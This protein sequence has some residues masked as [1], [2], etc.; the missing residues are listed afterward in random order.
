MVLER[1]SIILREPYNSDNDKE[2][3]EFI[4]AFKSESDP[5]TIWFFSAVVDNDEIGGV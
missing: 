5:K 2:A 1:P 3:F 4:K